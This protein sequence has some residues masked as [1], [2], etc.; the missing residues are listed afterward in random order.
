M[1]FTV[2]PG[3]YIKNEFGVRLEDNIVVTEHE[4]V[5]LM[6]MNYDLIVL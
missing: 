4:I 2:E 5:N 1:A 6:T 3:I